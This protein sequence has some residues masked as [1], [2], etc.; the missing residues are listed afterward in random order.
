MRM[1]EIL[2]AHV[3]Q[4]VI[5]MQNRRDSATGRNL[6]PKTIENLHSIL[7]GIFTTALND[8]VIYLHP[9]KGVKTP[10]VP[11]RVL[12]VITPEQFE[13]VYQSLPEGQVRLLVELAIESGLRWG[14]LTELRPCDIDLLT[15]ILTISRAVVEVRPAFHPD[16]GRFLV[17]DYPKDR[18][19]RRFKLS[20]SI[21]TSVTDHIRS[22]GLR[23]DDLLF[24]MPAPGPQHIKIALNPDRLGL[25]EPTE[26]GRRYQHGTLVA[27]SS[28]RCR[29]RHCKDAMAIYR[30]A[31]RDNPRRPRVRDTDGHIQRN[32]FRTQVWKPALTRA[33]LDFNVRMHDLRHA[34]ASWLLAGGADLQV[35][36]ER[37]GHASIGTTE[38]YLHT[39]PDAD[40]TAVDA[41]SKIR[42][43]ASRVSR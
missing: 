21:V 29:C 20:S 35:V 2:P 7:S 3:R 22:R 24:S 16:G 23:R 39:L 31:G 11:R 19:H 43:R 5:H 34:H 4:W 25:T 27:Y 30:A 9:C 26:S 37:L 42:G 32:W 41:L 36:K 1:N 28:G 15:R 13:V 10:T 33:G 40:D 6:A 17:K 38:R 18:E 8:Q 12:T 14:E